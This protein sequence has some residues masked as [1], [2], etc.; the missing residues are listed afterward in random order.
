MPVQMGWNLLNPCAK[1]NRFVNNLWVDL[2]S[3]RGQV[4]RSEEPA[5]IYP[6]HSCQGRETVLGSQRQESV[7]EDAQCPA[8]PG[9]IRYTTAFH[10]RRRDDDFGPRFPDFREELVYVFER[11]AQINIER[12]NIVATRPTE[13]EL[14]SL[15]ESKI[16]DV[17]QHL[18]VVTACGKRFRNRAGPVR[19][20]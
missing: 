16:H 13:R 2:H 8:H 4:E 7:C 17:V 11:V 14:K 10:V 9:N 5:V 19:T 3:G 1:Q 6:H 20:A 15:A 18:D 12:Y